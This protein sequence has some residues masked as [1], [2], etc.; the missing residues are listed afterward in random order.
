MIYE[1]ISD[2]NQLV[3]GLPSG[4]LLE[5]DT[6]TASFAIT[7]GE[8]LASL[9]QIQVENVDAEA[10][11]PGMVVSLQAAGAALVC[12][13]DGTWAEAFAQGIALTMQA[14]DQTAGIATVGYVSG[15]VG[16]TAGPIWLGAAG[17]I[18]C[19]ANPPNVAGQY[20]VPLGR[21]ISATEI[22]FQPGFPSLYR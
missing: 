2:M 6:G 16:L 15:F 3:S 9:G 10:F 12:I 5:I 21:A 22:I 17:T 1:K 18:I 14:V 7:V 13:P 8:L 11:T 20:N 4:A 19:S